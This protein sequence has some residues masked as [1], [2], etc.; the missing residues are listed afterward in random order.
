MGRYLHFASIDDGCLSV[1]LSDCQPQANFSTVLRR[2]E[3]GRDGKIYTWNMPRSRSLRKFLRSLKTWGWLK[4]TPEKFM[5]AREWIT[6]ARRKT[7][8]C[9]PVCVFWLCSLRAYLTQ[10]EIWKGRKEKREELLLFSHGR[11]RKVNRER[12]S[13]GESV[14]ARRSQQ[15]Q[16][17]RAIYPPA[18]QIQKSWVSQTQSR[19]RPTTWFRRSDL[20]PCFIFWV[21]WN[22]LP[23]CRN[24]TRRIYG[25]SSLLHTEGLCSL[26]G[27]KTKSLNILFVA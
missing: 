4:N 19:L 15:A 2:R 17:E 1:R 18:A 11:G 6:T 25:S 16:Q 20:R 9:A 24:N 27:L 3:I 26:V 13:L 5:F 7:A 10:K 12:N 23:Q 8:V 14:C 22:K 21:Y